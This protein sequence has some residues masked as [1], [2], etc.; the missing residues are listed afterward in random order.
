MLRQQQ[1]QFELKQQVQNEVRQ[2]QRTIRKLTA[3]LRCK[4]ELSQLGDD[5]L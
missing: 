3:Q 1:L 5:S 4:D 2:Y